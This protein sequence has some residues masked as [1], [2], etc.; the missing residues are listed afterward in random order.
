MQLVVHTL[1]SSAEAADVTDSPIGQSRLWPAATL[2]VFIGINIGLRLWIAAGRGD[3]VAWVLPAI[4][5]VLLIVLLATDPV[6]VR[7]HAESL[8]R[9]AITLVVILSPPPCGRLRSSSTT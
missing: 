6:T 8:H 3:P 4:E 7:R 9:T 1:R 2:V 5:A